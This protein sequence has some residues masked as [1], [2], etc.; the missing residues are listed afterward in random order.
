MRAALD[1]AIGQYTVD[2]RRYARAL[3]GNAGDADE[4]VQECLVRAASCAKSWSRVRD[5]KA[6]LFTVLHNAYVDWL[7]HE[8]RQRNHV[9]LQLVVPHGS[10]PESRTASLELH[11]LER[12]LTRL[13]SEQREVVL[14]IGLDGMSYQQAAEV[15]E[16]PVGTVMSRLSRGRDALRRMTAGEDRVGAAMSMRLAV[17]RRA[18]LPHLRAV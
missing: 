6:Y 8:R 1:H 18:Q 9:E 12:A 2:L 3:V 5:S 17:E 4:L 11:D 10:R 13:P 16:I 15:L 7:S 14:L